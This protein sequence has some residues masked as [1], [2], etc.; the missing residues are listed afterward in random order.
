AYAPRSDITAFANFATTFQTPTT[1]ELINAPPAPGQPCCPGGF[2]PD[3]EPQT[4]R[5]FEVGARAPLGP[6]AI[7]VA[8]FRIR[9]TNTLIPFQVEDVEG[10]EFF[11][12]AG[13]SLHKGL[14]VG[15]RSRLGPV[16]ASLAY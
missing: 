12:N 6:V 9:V 8:L 3:L 7:D 14:E 10:R 2:N 5:G 15:A 16:E 11:R 1:T 4:G 13:E